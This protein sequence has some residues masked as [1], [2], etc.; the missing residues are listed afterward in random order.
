VTP[1]SLWQVCFGVTEEFSGIPVGVPQLVCYIVYIFVDIL[2]YISHV[3][4]NQ[5]YGKRKR[6][7]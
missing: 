2:V 1:P 7:D 5:I 3:K 6:K 4:V